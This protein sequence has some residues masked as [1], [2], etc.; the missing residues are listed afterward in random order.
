MNAPGDPQYVR[1]MP[2]TGRELMSSA[3]WR[4][5]AHALNLSPREA[6]I[7]QSVFDDRS[8]LA[9]AHE[10]GISSHTVHT[11]FERL[12]HKLGVAS[13]VELVVRIVAEHLALSPLQPTAQ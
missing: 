7:V 1:S 6:C 10:L 4:D 11:H 3:A 2:F 8:E 12:Y 5:L 9:I 13:R